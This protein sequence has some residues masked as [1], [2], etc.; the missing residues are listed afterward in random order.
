M[1]TLRNKIYVCF[2]EQDKT[3]VLTMADFYEEKRTIIPEKEHKYVYLPERIERIKEFKKRY[4]YGILRRYEN[5][6]VK[7]Y[8]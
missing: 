4:N 3:K 2:E 1:K 8:L 5:F 6:H 7:L